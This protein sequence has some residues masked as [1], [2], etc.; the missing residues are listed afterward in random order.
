[1][2]RLRLF[3]VAALL[4]P[5]AAALQ[6]PTSTASLA[7]VTSLR[8]G[9]TYHLATGTLTPPT[10]AQS[11]LATLIT[12]GTAYSNSCMPP[13]GQNFTYVQALNG[14]DWVDDGRLPSRSSPAPA[15]GSFD[16]Y[17]ITELEF[18][19]VTRE[20]DPQLGGTGAQIR[21]RIFEDYDECTA[22][23][24]T[25]VPVA[26]YMLN[27]T[28]GSQTQGVAQ[29]ILLTVDLTGGF[30]FEIL[31]D[32]DGTFDNN[33]LLDRFGIALELLNNSVNSLGN[34]GG[35]ILAGESPA[36][37]TCAVG[38]ETYWGTNPLAAAGDG[39]DNG[40]GIY[41]DNAGTNTQ[42][43]SAGIA[44][45]GGVYLRL[46]ADLDDCNFNGQP[47]L[48]DISSGT[49][50][51]VN[52]NEIPDECE[53]AFIQTYCT[54]STTTNGCSPAIGGTGT[55]SA[56]ALSS[57]FTIFVTGM[58]GQKQGIVFYG[59][60]NTGFTP[61]QWSASSTSYLCV[62]LPTQRTPS[63]NS[64]GTFSACDGAMSLDWNAFRAANPTALGAPYSIGQH[65][66]AQVWFRDPPA[67]KTTNLTDAVEFS[68]LP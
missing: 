45:Y 49:S 13:A 1:M 62:K 42:C 55:P 43:F 46:I 27:M 34:V 11:G 41:L 25:Q 35:F 28:P 53:F 31:A 60:D 47:D 37:S 3:T 50:Q 64:G 39:L 56:S 16:R 10:A 44:G 29:G 9:G 8:H 6:S 15:V 14:W 67:P 66:Y 48:Y 2:N 54:T 36:S 38:D 52:G 19:Y 23:P 4:A 32:A 22:V 21:L 59:L 26:D 68:L 30:E 61:L 33:P 20:L 63:Q 17:R 57:G 51:D 58:E 7:Q 65:V 12:P 40:L 5:T 18:G 24:T